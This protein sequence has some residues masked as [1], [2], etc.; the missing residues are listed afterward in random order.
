MAYRTKSENGGNI[1]KNGVCEG[2][3]IIKDRSNFWKFVDSAG[4]YLKS[5]V[6][7]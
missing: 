5:A 4:K 6:S 7:V 1:R 3:V 2:R